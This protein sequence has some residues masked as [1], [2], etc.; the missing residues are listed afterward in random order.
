MVENFLCAW[1]VLEFVAEHLYPSHST[2]FHFR[3]NGMSEVFFYQ[4][5]NKVNN[6][7][8]NYSHEKFIYIVSE[9]GCHHL[10]KTP[11]SGLTG[12]FWYNI[13]GNK[14]NNKTINQLRYQGRA[15][16]P[17][18]KYFFRLLFFLFCEK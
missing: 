16:C 2:R 1:K 4:I 3:R 9:T 17:V 13:K 7:R 6:R 12:E 15:C 8:K 11:G 10:A 14:Q 18:A 5:M